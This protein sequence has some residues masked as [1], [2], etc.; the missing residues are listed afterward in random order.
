[1]PQHTDAAHAGIEYGNVVVFSHGVTHLF[2]IQNTGCC[3]AP[4]KASPGRGALFRV[5][6]FYYLIKSF[7]R[8]QRFIDFFVQL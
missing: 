8:L 1:V 7:T 6:S 2:R 4:A 3:F 5:N